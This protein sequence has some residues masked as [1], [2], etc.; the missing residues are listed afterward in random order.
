[1]LCRLHTFVIVGFVYLLCATGGVAQELKAELVTSPQVEKRITTVRDVVKR[2]LEEIAKARIKG[3]FTSAKD[4]TARASNL[5]G[6]AKA[7]VAKAR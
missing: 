1:M 5:D 4:V 7:K 2:L 6:Y 3:A